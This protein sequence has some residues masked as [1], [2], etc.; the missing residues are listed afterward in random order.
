M[1]GENL[2]VA[3]VPLED[4]L[5]LGDRLRVGTAELVVVQPRLPCFK[6]GIRFADPG[7]VKRFLGAGRSGYYLRILTEGD[8]GV[9]RSDRDPRAA[10][11]RDR[12]LGDH[13]AVRPRP[14]RRRRSRGGAGRRCAA[15][16][17]EAV[18]RARSSSKPSRPGAAPSPEPLVTATEE[19]TGPYSGRTAWARNLQT[20][21]REFVETEIGGAAVLLVAARRG[22]PLDQRRCA[23]LRLVLEH[24]PVDRRRRLGHRA[25]PPA[26][27]E[28]RPDDV[29]LL[30]RRARGAPRV[31]PRRAARAAPVRP[32]AARR[33][34][35][36]RGAD[37][38]LPELQCRPDRRRTAGGSRCRPIRRSPSA[39][40]RSSGRASRPGCAPSCSRSPSSTTSS[41]SS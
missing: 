38:D 9:W 31:R 8:V 26:V 25:R 21:L 2:T 20:P 10:P 15:G 3:G 12:S 16:R 4:E 27:G 14:R 33:A 23:L 36:H 5:A 6:L 13:T 40:S 41:R 32:A 29:L 39:C 30:R 37:R 11:G 18:L 35:R 17:L 34:G 24:D 7:M 1:F 28:Q 19:T 22:A